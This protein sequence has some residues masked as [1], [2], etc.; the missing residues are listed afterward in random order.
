VQFMSPAGR[1]VMLEELDDATNLF[2]Q[3]NES[4]ERLSANV[5]ATN[6]IG[7]DAV[8]QEY[9]QLLLEVEQWR[10]D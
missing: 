8:R 10:P 4:L 6:N 7:E 9:E 1:V 2:M 5:R 3:V